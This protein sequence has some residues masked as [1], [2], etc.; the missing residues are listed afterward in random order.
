VVNLKFPVVFAHRGA[1]SFAPENSLVAFQKAIEMGCDGI[2]LD[3]RPC[4]SGEIVVFHDR[5][6]QRMTGTR[7]AVHKMRFAEIKGLTLKHNS[8]C[9]ERIPRLEEVLDLAR[10]KVRINIDVKKE[11]FT[12][13]GLEDKILKIIKDFHLEDNVIISSFNPIVLKRIAQI[14][15]DLH[16]GFIF[17]NRSSMMM[18]NGH[19][20]RSLHA[21]YRILSQRYI[22]HLNQKANQVYSWT[23]DKAQAMKKQIALGVDGIITNKPEI[24]FQLKREFYQKLSF[25]LSEYRTGYIFTKRGPDE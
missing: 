23:V 5:H 24:Y 2:E 16:L 1:N 15:P 25:Q 9:S 17:R 10:K 8:S 19:P 22:G 3:V 21:R 6:T 14:R 11:S 7:G 13:N 20:V 4:S 12:R 18:L